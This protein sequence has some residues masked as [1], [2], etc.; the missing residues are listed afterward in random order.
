M[1]THR[2]WLAG[3]GW[4]VV[5]AD[6]TMRLMK[7]ADLRQSDRS[8]WVIWQVKDLGGTGVWP[9]KNSFHKSV[10]NWI[11]LLYIWLHV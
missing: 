3:R 5:V 8:N 9:G 10:K 4:Q 2:L 7:F 11:R 1:E 6:S